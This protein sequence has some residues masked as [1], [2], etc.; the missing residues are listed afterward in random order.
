MYYPIRWKRYGSDPLYPIII[1]SIVLC[2]DIII[3]F[4]VLF[5]IFGSSNTLINQ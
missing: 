5:I 2:N 4:F 3:W 1:T